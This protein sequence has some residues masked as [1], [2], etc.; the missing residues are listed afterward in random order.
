MANHGR[1]TL[2]DAASQRGH[3]MMPARPNCAIITFPIMLSS[4]RDPGLGKTGRERR[5]PPSTL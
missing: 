2:W 5:L 3:Q 1:S 4:W